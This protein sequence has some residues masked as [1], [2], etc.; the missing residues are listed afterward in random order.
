LK[1]NDIL[2]IIE[3]ERIVLIK[4]DSEVQFNWNNW[5]S[6]RDIHDKKLEDRYGDSEIKYISVNKYNE[7]EIVVQ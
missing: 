4:N 1:V 3:V 5:D 2:K 7:L 6:Y